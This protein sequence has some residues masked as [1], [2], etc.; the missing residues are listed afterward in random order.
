MNRRSQAGFSFIEILVVMSI[1]VVLV[2]MVTV[3]V[4]RAQEQARRTESLNNVRNMVQALSSESLTK[5]WPPYSGKNFTLSLIP[6]GI[7]DIRNPDNIEIFFSPG[8]RIF[9]FDKVGPDP[10]KEVT[11]KA[12]RDGA[13]FHN[14]TSYAGRMN[15]DDDYVITAGD[16]QM[17]SPIISD[18]DEGA[19]HHPQGMVI[20]YTNGTAKFVE[21]GDIGMAAPDEK[22]PEPFL[23]EQAP[24]D[25]LRTLSSQ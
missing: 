10:Y 4:P 3:I 7:V 8:D 1:I 23:G 14:L 17:V 21:W 12:L 11:A 20:G 22:S 24:V 2:G 25:L 16:E 6:R 19:L 5:N 15:A 18:D 13:D 9:T